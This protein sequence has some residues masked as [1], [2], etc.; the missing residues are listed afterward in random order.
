MEN[1]TNYTCTI[2]YVSGKICCDINNPN[3]VYA[4]YHSHHGMQCNLHES[5]LNYNRIMELCKTVSDA[6]KEI[7]L[8]NNPQGEQ[9]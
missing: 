8:L 7:H 6:I 3:L 5:K 1:K 2:N 9:Q 4:D